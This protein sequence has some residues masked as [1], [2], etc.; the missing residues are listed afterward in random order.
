MTHPWYVQCIFIQALMATTFGPEDWFCFE[1]TCAATYWLTAPFMSITCGCAIA[2]IP[3]K[4][5]PFILV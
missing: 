5:Y 1:V 4:I 2:F 3:V